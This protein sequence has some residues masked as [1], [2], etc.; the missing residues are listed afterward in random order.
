MITMWSYG[1]E[2]KPFNV[3]D[4]MTLERSFQIFRKNPTIDLKLTL[5]NGFTVNFETM[6]VQ[7]TKDVG[8]RSESFSEFGLKRE[9]AE[10]TGEVISYPL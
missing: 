10:P 2:Y 7:D 8:F 4:R 1:E 3:I 5:S 6:E 9:A